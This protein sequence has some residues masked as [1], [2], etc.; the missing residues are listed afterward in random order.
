LL[1]VPSKSKKKGK[2]EKLSPAE[3]TQ[4]QPG[5]SPSALSL[6]RRFKTQPFPFPAISVS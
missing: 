6:S 4:Q 5:Q 3:K 1:C 2:A